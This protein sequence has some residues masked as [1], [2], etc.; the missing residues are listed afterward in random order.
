MKKKTILV[1]G[2]GGLIGSAVA[3]HFSRNDVKRAG[4]KDF[5]MEDEAFVK[6][7]ESADVIMNFAGAP[8]LKRWNR[9]NRKEIMESRIETTQK[10]GLIM[11][12]GKRK[13]RRYI[14]A[15]A[16]GIYDDKGRHTEDSVNT[17]RGFLKEVVEQWEREAM[18]LEG[19]GCSVCILRIGVVLSRQGGMLTKL[20]PFFRAGLG[21]RIGNGKQA[22]SWIHLEDLL[23]A[24]E[25]ITDNGKNGIYNLVAPGTCNNIEFI[26]ALGKALD[27]PAIM[28]VPAAALELVYGKAAMM[29]CSGQA[30]VPERL[31][32]EGFD[33]RFPDIGS[34][35][36]D[37]VN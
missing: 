12:R 4:R 35:V 30:V 8:V 34:A 24:V 15:S 9:K 25:F 33:F 23:R 18:K 20:L 13:E 10:L 16:I 6:R 36:S 5:M 2:A 1:A 17:G 21:G 29:I 37:I 19:P 14:S 22:F 32:R 27:R 11:E 31:L 28:V 7:Y 26:R 3:G